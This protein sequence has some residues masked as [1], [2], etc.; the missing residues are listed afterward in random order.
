MKAKSE[1]DEDK[2][3]ESL[4]LYL[5]KVK[6]LKIIKSQIERKKENREKLTKEEENF[7]NDFYDI[8]AKERLIPLGNA[9][10]ASINV[11]KL[12]V[13]ISFFISSLIFTSPFFSLKINY[14]RRLSISLV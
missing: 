7:L 12:L 8:L 6:D 10:N 3:N 11:L 1:F 14:F 9:S 5:S 4:Q 13:L 2:P